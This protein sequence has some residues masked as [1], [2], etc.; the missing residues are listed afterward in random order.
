[1]SDYNNK[2]NNSLTRISSDMQV[3][4]SSIVNV[5]ADYAGSVVD[6]QNQTRKN[7]LQKLFPDATQ[8]AIKMGELKL[9]QTEFEFRKKALEMVRE[10]HTQALRETCNQYLVQAK[11]TGRAE[12]A[13]LLMQKA[14]ELQAEMDR[15]FD[16]F[17]EAVEKKT[18]KLES[19]SNVVLKRKMEEQLEKEIH[20][21]VEMRDQLIR[22][23]NKIVEE[24]V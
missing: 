6:A 1:M 19:L 10:T 15:V 3:S 23:F 20:E 2:Q 21:F 14:Q 13:K 24:G 17:I 8:R 4:K 7:L 22:K 12:T 16:K 5:V 9:I 11:A 18:L